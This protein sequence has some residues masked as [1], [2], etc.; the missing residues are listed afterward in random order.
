MP[1]ECKGLK[2]VHLMTGLVNTVLYNL[3]V[4]WP[5]VYSI[6]Q[7]TIYTSYR[8]CDLNA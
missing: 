5:E 1:G 2:H 7:K 6:T 4:N 3:S 8:L